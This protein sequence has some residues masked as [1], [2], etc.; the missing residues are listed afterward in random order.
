MWAIICEAT[1]KT[2][3]PFLNRT[4]PLYKRMQE[5]NNGNGSI[6]S[7]LKSMLSSLFDNYFESP[8]LFV[9]QINLIKEILMI[10]FEDT[11]DAV[12]ILDTIYPRT[13]R[14]K[15]VLC[16]DIDGS[17]NKSDFDANISSPILNALSNFKPLDEYSLFDF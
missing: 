8:T 17:Y 10:L 5:I 6:K 3:R 7:Y 15:I 16:R 2:Q 12:K 9:K 11:D 14:S 13:Q 1:E 4:I